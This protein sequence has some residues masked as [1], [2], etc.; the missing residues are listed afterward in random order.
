MARLHLRAG[1]P[2]LV[3]PLDDSLT[4]QWQAATGEPFSVV[5][6]YCV[7]PDPSGRAR[8]C[9]TQGMLTFDER[10]VALQLSQI[11]RGVRYGGPSR[12]TMATAISSWRPAAVVIAAGSISALARHLTGYFGRP[13][14]EVGS[15]LGW[16]LGR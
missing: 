12:L 9:G 2:V 15:V 7:A 4:M 10:M 13:T 8:L 11:A 14:A 16:R 6:G 1:A 5:S 3:L